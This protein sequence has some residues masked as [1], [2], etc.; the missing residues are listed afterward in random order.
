M[1]GST[2]ATGINQSW[3][4]M[5][6]ILQFVE[7]GNLWAYYENDLVVADQNFQ[8]DYYILGNIPKFYNCPSRRGKTPSTAFAFWNG[9]SP[10]I[11]SADYAG[12][13]GTSSLGY[14][15]ADGT[16]SSLTGCFVGISHARAATGTPVRPLIPT[17][18]GGSPLSLPQIS[19]GTSNTMMIGEKA[20]NKLTMMSN[21][22]QTWGDDQGYAEGLAW[23]NI[24]YG[25]LG[26]LADGL[27]RSDPTIPLANRKYLSTPVQDQAA[28]VPPY[29]DP[30]KD[31]A[32]PNWRWGS[33]HPG[34]F[35][36]ALADGSVRNITY[37]INQ[38]T[39]Y[40]LCNRADGVAFTLNQ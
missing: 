32:W 25:T 13:G 4:W 5:Y 33:A 35:N 38:L 36:A 24:R 37:S 21:N 40:Y 27:D 2:P 39:L 20:V 17:V 12:N 3:G 1:N 9:T 28:P 14:G 26:D 15:A 8:G 22:D 6:Q 34:G 23:D 7:Q 29:A 16:S 18:V 10:T 30:S 19:D 11:N 31:A